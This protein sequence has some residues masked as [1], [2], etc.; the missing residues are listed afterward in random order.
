MVKYQYILLQA[1]RAIQRG[2]TAIVFDVTKNHRAA[3]EL[4]TSLKKPLSR[5]VIIMDGKDADQLMSIVE[6]TSIARARISTEFQ[7]QQESKVE[8][9]SI[10][11]L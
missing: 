11:V 4:R 7:L 6:R 5:P 2:A 3:H 9:V 1:R 10:Q 8:I